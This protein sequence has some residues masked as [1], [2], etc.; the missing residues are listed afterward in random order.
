MLCTE[1]IRPGGGAHIG[2]AVVHKACLER[3]DISDLARLESKLQRD[4][5]FDYRGH[6]L[7]PQSYLNQESRRWVPGGFI[8]RFTGV[9]NLREPDHPWELLTAHDDEQDTLDAADAHA[10]AIGRRWVDDNS[11]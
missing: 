11:R 7:E 8:L 9:V 10:M 4:S 6:R 2:L 5:A 1:G 3:S